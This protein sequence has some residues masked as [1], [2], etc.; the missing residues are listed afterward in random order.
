MGLP[1]FFHVENNYSLILPLVGVGGVSF[2]LAGLTSVRLRLFF[3]RHYYIP[4]IILVLIGCMLYLFWG[5][6]EFFLWLN[7]FA[8]FLGF[9][10]A[11]TE[12]KCLFNS[13][14]DNHLGR[15]ASNLQLYNT[16]KVSGICFGFVV[17]A[18]LSGG[19]LSSGIAL[20]ITSVIL[21]ILL[22][23]AFYTYV[24]EKSSNIII[25]VDRVGIFRDFFSKRSFRLLLF[26]LDV[27]LFTYWYIYIPEKMVDIGFIGWQIS[28]FLAVQALLHISMQSVWRSLIISYGATKCF[29]LSF[30]FHALIVFFIGHIEFS[31]IQGVAFFAVMGCVNSGT[32][33]ASSLIYYNE[34]KRS[35][36]NNYFHLIASH[37]GKLVGVSI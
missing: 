27:G 23:V 15:M 26:V 33:L 35:L 18:L 3:I 29:W 10:T 32:F 16:L 17:A 36:N 34:G 22:V 5:M 31:F 11:N 8:F 20:Y 21:L 28:V 9:S 2:L 30:I 12:A 13:V 25:S 7:Y 6:G 1:L 14:L 37:V 4:S 24:Q 19:A